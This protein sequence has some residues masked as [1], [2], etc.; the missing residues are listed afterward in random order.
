MKILWEADALAA[1]V[2][3]ADAGFAVSGVSFD[4]RTIQP[5]E[6]FVALQD[7][8]DGHDFIAAALARGAA[9]SLVSRDVMPGPVLRVQNTLHGLNLLAAAARTRTRAKIVA[10]TGSVGKTTTKEMLRRCLG[11]FGVVH[12]AESSFN[13]HI[14]VP[15]TL[16]RLPLDAAFGVFEIGMNHPGEILPLT[17]LVRPDVAVVTNVARVHLGL[18]GSEDAIA[19]EK[20]A[21]FAGLVDGGAAILPGDS[22]HLLALRQGVPAHARQLVTGASGGDARLLHVSHTDQSATIEA[23]ICGVTVKF[24]LAAPGA[25]MASNALAVLTV[26]AALGLDVAAAAAALDGF[27][28]FAGRGARRVVSLP[29]GR[30]KILLLDESYNA[31]AVSVRAALAVLALQPGRHVAVLGDMLELGDATEAEHLSLRDDVLAAATQT[32]ACGT[33]MGRLFDS[34]PQAKQGAHAPDAAS[35]APILL[36]A[37]RDGDTVLVKGSYG[38]RMRDIILCLE[39]PA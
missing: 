20:A 23:E 28:P 25:H 24:T 33:A 38:S 18:M 11:A 14:G 22:G 4:S 21:V 27:S 16:A 30:G 12:A 15:L 9:G 1:A 5:G 31:S 7:A 32:F 37:L 17:N 35:L 6:L 3:T 19:A 39:G 36:S 13:N 10:V 34:L 29:G 2:G 8:R 26:A